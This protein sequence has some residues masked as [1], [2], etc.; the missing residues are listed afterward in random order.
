MEQRFTL[1]TNEKPGMFYLVGREK[2]NSDFGLPS[3]LLLPCLL[4]TVN[5]SIMWE[6]MSHT[7]E[8]S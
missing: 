5:T 7:P 1:S 6:V 4:F 2:G 8:S 3:L